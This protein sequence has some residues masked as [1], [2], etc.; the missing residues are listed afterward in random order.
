[1]NICF[2]LNI[3]RK[4]PVDHIVLDGCGKDFAYTVTLRFSFEARHG[5]VEMA[6]ICSGCSKCVKPAIHLHHSFGFEFRVAD[7]VDMPTMVPK[8]ESR[9]VQKSQIQYVC[10]MPQSAGY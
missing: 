7:P 8:L 6:D 10:S 9:F 2:L 4:N 5:A 3:Y 1:M